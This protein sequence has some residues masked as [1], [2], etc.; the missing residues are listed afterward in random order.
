MLTKDIS[1]SRFHDI[2]SI[3]LLDEGR[4]AYIAKVNDYL[5]RNKRLLWCVERFTAEEA[6]VVQGIHEKSDTLARQASRMLMQQNLEVFFSLY[7]AHLSEL[8]N[9]YV[10]RDKEMG[11]NFT[12]AEERLRSFYSSLKEKQPIRYTQFVGALHEPEKY[13][14]P[15]CVQP[16]DK[17]S[18]EN[19]VI[20]AIRQGIPASELKKE[21]LALALELGFH[22]SS[23]QSMVLAYENLTALAEK[24]VREKQQVKIIS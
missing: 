13:Y 5:F 6:K 19:D 14:L 24:A 8:N 7:H 23:E 15:V 20:R 1:R 3:P 21:L 22:I 18:F 16:L 11:R 9:E 10:V 4:K 2:S 17:N 12:E